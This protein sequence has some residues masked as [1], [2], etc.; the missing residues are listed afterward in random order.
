MHSSFR[1]VG[2]RNTASVPSVQF[3]DPTSRRNRS[4]DVARSPF[5]KSGK[6]RRGEGGKGRERER[7]REKGAYEDG[8][9]Y[10]R[11]EH[12]RRVNL[13]PRA[14]EKKT[15]REKKKKKRKGEKEGGGFG[16]VGVG[17]IRRVM[18]L[19]TDSRIAI[20]HQAPASTNRLVKIR[21]H[22]SASGSCPAMVTM[23]QPS[24]GR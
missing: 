4:S 16:G 1:P 7:G 6:E 2:P 19:S 11:V 15:W 17:R 10:N 14:N 23:V 3:L 21:R 12:V 13:K 20:H 5:R 22:S 24:D 8:R 18:N 9:M